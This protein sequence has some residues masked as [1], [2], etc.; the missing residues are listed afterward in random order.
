MQTLFGNSDMRDALN[1]LD[2]I[3]AREGLITA[4]ETLATTQQ[5]LNKIDRMESGG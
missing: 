3:T 2:N 1:K 5:I 4:T